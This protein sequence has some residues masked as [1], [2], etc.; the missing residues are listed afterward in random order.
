MPPHHFYAKRQWNACVKAGMM[1]GAAYSEFGR[2][3]TM[4]GYV[5]V[6]HP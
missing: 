5:K 1:D 6:T 3:N 2:L 4:N